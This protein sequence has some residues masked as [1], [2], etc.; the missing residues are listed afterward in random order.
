MSERILTHHQYEELQRYEHGRPS[1]MFYAPSTSL[2]RRGFLSRV[3]NSGETRAASAFRI[4][5][6]GLSA[7]TAYRERYGVAAGVSR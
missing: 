7:L 2:T 3:P 1:W 5:D 4:T 6:A